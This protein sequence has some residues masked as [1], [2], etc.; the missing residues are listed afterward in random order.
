MSAAPV[1]RKRWIRAELL[2]ALHLY[3]RITFGQQDK[4]NAEVKALAARL[5]RTPSSV[6]MKLNNFTSLDPDERQRGVKGLKG[7]SRLDRTVWAEFQR[8]P[9]L[10]ATPDESWFGADGELDSTQEAFKFPRDWGGSTEAFAVG[11]VRLAQRYFRRVVLANFGGRCALTG[12]RGP[13]LVVASHILGWSEAPEHRVDPANGLSLN[14]LHDAAFDCKLVTFDEN[15][16][17]IVGRRIRRA[18]PDGAIAEAFDRYAGV[19]LAIPTKHLIN[20]E[21]LARHRAAYLALEAG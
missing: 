18:L 12:V 1:A 4:C 20:Q 3:G 9:D 11:R 7:A 19:P 13:E 17:F 15:C 2:L 10:V 21:F 14:R 5:G 8:N 6:S 16:R